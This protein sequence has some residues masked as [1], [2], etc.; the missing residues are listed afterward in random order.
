MADYIFLVFII[1][2]IYCCILLFQSFGVKRNKKNRFILFIEAAVLACF[3][4]VISV[5]LYEW[6][7][8]KAIAVLAVTSIIM[9]LMFQIRC[10]KALVLSALFYVVNLIAEWITLVIAG[11]AVPLISGRPLDLTDSFTL[12]S[13]SAISKVLLL[14][15][16][17]AIRKMVGKKTADVLTVRELWALVTVSFITIFS[18]GAMAIE[19][20]FVNHTSQPV[21]F[22]YVAIG[23]LAINFIVYYLINDVME[24]EVKL[25]EHA[26]FREKVKSETAMYRSISE[27]LEKQR[28][29]THEYKNQIAVISAL[30][31]GEQHQELK[32]YIEKIDQ[33]MHLSMDAIDTNHVMVNA[34][35][36]TKY[37]EAQDKGIVFVLKVNDL[38]ELKIAEEDIVIILSNLLNNAIE[39]CERCKDKVIKLKFVLKEGQAVISVKN[40]M[41]SQ[42]IAE[43]GQL[44][45]T[46][47]VEKGEHGMGVQNVIEAVEKY[48]GRYLIDYEKEKFQFSILI[49]NLLSGYHKDFSG[50]GDSQVRTSGI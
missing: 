43:N 8:I 21:S 11:R 42:P 37:R 6:F 19:I 7:F 13:V 2:E 45:T 38:S 18:V 46:K 41:E 29:K 31:A 24:R 33:A 39:A 34:I 50:Q 48:N 16:V 35:L 1:A 17:L 44:L 22:M 4:F 15:I 30:A 14:G 27:N 12:N 23:I 49:P 5:F 28:K 10:S 47:T 9:L 36:N 26:A 25:R 20:D 40:S 3:Y 32:A